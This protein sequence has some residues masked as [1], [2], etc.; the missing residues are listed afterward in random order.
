MGFFTHQT[1][2][3][4]VACWTP[5]LHMEPPV[6]SV[7]VWL[8][9]LLIGDAQLACVLQ[10]NA[11]RGK[12]S[13]S[14]RKEYYFMETELLFKLSPVEKPTSS[15]IIQGKHLA[16]RQLNLFLIIFFLLEHFT[17]IATEAESCLSIA[18]LCVSLCSSIH[19]CIREIFNPLYCLC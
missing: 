8:L 17:Q 11:L 15:K 18:K 4:R 16:A 13:K 19:W 7:L 14:R 2:Q 1:T 3:L 10:G 6:A 5:E 12:L 9:S